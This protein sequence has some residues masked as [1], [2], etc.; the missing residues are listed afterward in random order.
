MSS[1]LEGT[2]AF[3]NF[4]MCQFQRLLKSSATFVLPSQLLQ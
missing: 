2:I 4:Y 3:T 1:H